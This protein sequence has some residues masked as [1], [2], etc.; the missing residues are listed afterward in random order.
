MNRQECGE[1]SIQ[2][3]ISKIILSDAFVGRK[4]LV[5]IAGTHLFRRSWMIWESHGVNEFV[6]TPG[7]MTN[8]EVCATQVVAF[9]V[10]QHLHSFFGGV[11]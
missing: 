10:G 11:S 3:Y 2:V 6:T 5:Q 7:L 4:F 1:H 9:Q 8:K